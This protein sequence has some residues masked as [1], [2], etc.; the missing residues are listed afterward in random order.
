MSL[1]LRVAALVST[2]F[3]VVACSGTV[4]PKPKDDPKTGTSSAELRFK[5]PCTTSS[6]GVSPS[7]SEEGAAFTCAQVDTTC[8]W[9]SGDPNGAVSWRECEPSECVYP[10]IAVV[11][12]AGSHALPPRCG[13]ENDAACAVYETCV[14]D[15]VDAGPATD[16]CTTEEC[17]GPIADIAEIC[18]DGSSAGLKCLRRNGKCSVG[19]GCPE[20]L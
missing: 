5:S 17:G 7:S 10:A 15:K 14:P 16:D 19:S 11:C 13:S 4:E 12:P 2:S 3:L 1:S 8:A 18:S 9:N 20:N 6:C